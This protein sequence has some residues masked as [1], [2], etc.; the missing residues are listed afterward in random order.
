ML[1]DGVEREEDLIH[2]IVLEENLNWFRVIHEEVH[3]K[4]LRGQLLVLSGQVSSWKGIFEIIN[5]LFDPI[6]VL[7]ELNKQEIYIEGLLNV[8]TVLPS[9]FELFV[10][11]LWCGGWLKL[12]FICDI[13]SVFLYKLQSHLA[14]IYILAEKIEDFFAVV[15][16]D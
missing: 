10:D 14:D 4:M 11:F 3:C 13:G 16:L 9:A 1:A 6:I 15:S 12:E 7:W 5:L 8:P 2:Y